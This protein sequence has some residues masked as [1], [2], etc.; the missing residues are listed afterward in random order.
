MSNPLFTAITGLSGNQTALGVISSNIANSNT[1]GFKSGTAQFEELFSQ[2]LAQPTSA[3]GLPLQ[4]GLGSRVGSVLTSFAQGTVQVTGRG[5]DAAII[6]NGLF[7]VSGSSGLRFTR[8]GNFTIDAQGNLVNPNGLRVQGYTSV[9]SNG[10]LIASGALN[11]IN[12]PVSVTSPPTPTTLLSVQANFDAS[13]QSGTI[14]NLEARVFDS[15]GGDHL[16][17]LEFTRGA[18]GN[19]WDYDVK[20]DGNSLVPALTGTVDFD[21]NGQITNPP[22][23]GAGSP[24]TTLTIPGQTLANGATLSDITMTLVDANGKSNFTGFDA[25]SA[26]T[27]AEQDGSASGVLTGL[28]IGADGTISGR[29]S[30]G[31][32][33]PL[34]QLAIAT[35]NNFEGLTKEGSNLYSANLGSGTANIGAPGTA[36]RGTIA[37]NSI[38]SSNVDL[39]TEFSAL[40]LAQRGFQANSRVITMSDQLLQDVV[41]LIR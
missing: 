15:V 32:T 4:V 27:A 40:I 3:A 12:I 17:T 14:F 18:A 35:F 25:P 16:L 26:T 37:G 11:D 38:E 10:N 1:I 22:P 41:N 20:V 34:A 6:G 8:A 7:V 24:L 9:D 36:G 5:T 19:S 21:A 39:S 2:Q 33:T 29:F 31:Q 28:S 13:A 23:D 30:N